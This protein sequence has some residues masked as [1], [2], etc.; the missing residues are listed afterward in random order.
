MASF[1]RRVEVEHKG[2]IDLVTSVDRESEKVVL[3]TLGRAF[4]D[5]AVLTE[6]GDPSWKNREW[7]WVVDPLDGTTN[8]AKGFPFFCVS[9]ALARQGR[10]VAAAVCNP[11]LGEMFTAARGRGA[12][13]NR[14]KLCVSTTADLSE[15]FL[16]TGFPYDIRESGRDNL[17]NFSHLVKRTLAVRRAGSAAL[18]L[19]YVA[20]GRFDGFWELKLS[21]WDTAAAA[22]LV[23]EAGGRV[24]TPAGRPWNMKNG[25]IAATNGLIHKEL[26]RE[27]RQAKKP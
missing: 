5:Y 8:Y 2:A 23:R 14:R 21:P 18:D 25:D 16:A 26:V 19:S 11:V 20:A 1:G 15:A 17:D 12:F 22:L 4:P 7:C 9:I 27:L 6:E 3:D 10:A 24:T 13:L